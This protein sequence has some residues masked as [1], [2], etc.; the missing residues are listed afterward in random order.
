MH[1]YIC[2]DW[3]GRATL[4]HEAASGSGAR[5]PAENLDLAPL[6]PDGIA[7]REQMSPSMR[8]TNAVHCV[9]L[10]WVS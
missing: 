5:L 7:D 10:A 6:D 8:S 9:T 2:S 1:R 3:F 4:P